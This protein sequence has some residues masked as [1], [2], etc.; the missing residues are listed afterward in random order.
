MYQF[1]HFNEEKAILEIHK[2]FVENLGDDLIH[3]FIGNPRELKDGIHRSFCPYVDPVEHIQILPFFF[4]G[5]YHIDLCININ[6]CYTHGDVINNNLKIIGVFTNI[7]HISYDEF[8]K[9]FINKTDI[10]ILVGI[11]THLQEN[12]T[13][14]QNS[15]WFRDYFYFN[16]SI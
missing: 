10:D 2:L 8:C 6:A 13:A 5:S 3:H 14:F 15:L 11:M 12:T 16:L 1:I 9:K 4:Y 7:H